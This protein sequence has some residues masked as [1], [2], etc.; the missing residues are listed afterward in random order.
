MLN[1]IWSILKNLFSFLWER[2][3]WTVS[4]LLVIFIIFLILSGRNKDEQINH[5]THD[6]Q[7]LADAKK[8]LEEEMNGLSLKITF[9]NRN[10]DILVRGKNGDIAHSAGYI[11]D[12]GSITFKEFKLIKGLFKN[13]SPNVISGTVQ[14]VSTTVETKITTKIVDNLTDGWFS[15]TKKWL[16]E[17]FVGP[18]YSGDS[19]E[20]KIQDRGFTLRPGIG[21][22]YDRN[23][24]YGLNL[25]LDSKLLYYKRLSAGLGVNPDVVYIWGSTHLDRLTFGYVNNFEFMMGYGYLLNSSGGNQFIIGLRSNL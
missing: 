10:Y 4:I 1:V 6:T 19:S 12:E 15:K 11:P 16:Y 25:G 2:K 23:Q 21:I 20:I 22:V 24:K 14:G 8:S 5:L 13:D 18:I 7:A 3:Q 9:K 17:V